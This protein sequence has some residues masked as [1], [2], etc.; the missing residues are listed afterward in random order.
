MTNKIIMVWSY[1]TM[2]TSNTILT[3]FDYATAIEGIIYTLKGEVLCM[4]T[5]ECERVIFYHFT[6]EKKTKHH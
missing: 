1:F 6:S 5:E 2:T 3:E 4:N